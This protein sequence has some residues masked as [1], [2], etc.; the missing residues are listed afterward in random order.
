MV[1]LSQ[2]IISCKFLIF[3]IDFVIWRSFPIFPPKKGQAFFTPLKTAQRFTLFSWT[4]LT[5]NV[6]RGLNEQTCEEIENQL[7]KTS[8]TPLTSHCRA[9]GAAGSYLTMNVHYILNW[10]MK[11]AVNKQQLTVQVHSSLLSCW[12]WWIRGSWLSRISQ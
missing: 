11:S 3:M 4:H 5:S 12:T 1:K 7:A 8:Y 9:S 2:N 6:I 10:E